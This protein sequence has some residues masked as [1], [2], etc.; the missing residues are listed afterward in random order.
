MLFRNTRLKMRGRK[1]GEEGRRNL[2]IAAWIKMS[3]TESL[4]SG[5]VQSKCNE[6]TLVS[7]LCVSG[8]VHKTL[9]QHTETA[10]QVMRVGTEEEIRR[11]VPSEMRTGLSLE[12]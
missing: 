5:R 11:D 3:K 7:L 10:L 6:D 2:F 8:S 1:G 9:Q 4:P 12:E